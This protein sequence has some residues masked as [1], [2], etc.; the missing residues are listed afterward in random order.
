MYFTSR[1]GTFHVERGCTS[2]REG[3][4]FTSRGVHFTSRG[5]ALHVER[6]RTSRREGVHFSSRREGAHNILA[7]CTQI[8]CK[9]INTI[10]QFILSLLEH[11]QQI[12]TRALLWYDSLP[13]AMYTDFWSLS[14]VL[15]Y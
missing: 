8:Q 12:S 3:V 1:G 7:K 13:L 15:M 5:G 11:K 10:T 4:H 9:G 2:R 6:G 14:T